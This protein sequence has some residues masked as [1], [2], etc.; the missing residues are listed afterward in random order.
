MLFSTSSQILCANSGVS[1]TDRVS[2]FGVGLIEMKVHCDPALASTL[3][4]YRFRQ[5]ETLYEQ[6]S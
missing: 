1:C 3:I 4:D 5:G 6:T 2:V